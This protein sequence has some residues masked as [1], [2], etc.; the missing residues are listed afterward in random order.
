MGQCTTELRVDLPSNW[1]ALKSLFEK[2][3]AE[4]P[5]DK[6]WLCLTEDIWQAKSS[7][8]RFCVD[9]GWYPQGDLNGSFT[10]SLIEEDNWESPVEQF[11]AKDYRIMINWIRATITKCQQLIGE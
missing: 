10:G 5:P 3:P 1:S 4:V 2:D 11:S 9:L 6:R 7:N 8:G